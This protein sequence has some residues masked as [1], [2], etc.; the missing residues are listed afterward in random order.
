M[1]DNPRPWCF[2]VTDGTLVALA[3]IWIRFFHAAYN[4]SPKSTTFVRS[5]FGASALFKNFAWATPN[6][7]GL[8]ENII[9]G[10]TVHGRGRIAIP[11]STG[12]LNREWVSPS[13]QPVRLV[14]L[15]VAFHDEAWPPLEWQLDF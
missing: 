15:H 7:F 11:L 12:Q 14:V 4:T 3:P 6:H 1:L 9:R 5:D 8:P 13:R 2:E 10:R